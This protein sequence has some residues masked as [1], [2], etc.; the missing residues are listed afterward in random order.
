MGI[1]LQKIKGFDVAEGKFLQAYEIRR[2]ELGDQHA[3][4]QKAQVCVVNPTAYSLIP[5]P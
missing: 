4:T 1:A 5:K 2:K 3:L